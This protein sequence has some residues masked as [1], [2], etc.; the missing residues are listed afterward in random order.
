MIQANQYHQQLKNISQV[1]LNSGM[2]KLPAMTKTNGQPVKLD[3]QPDLMVH[4]LRRC[5]Y[6]FSTAELTF[7]QSIGLDAYLEYQLAPEEMNT[8]ALE[9]L[10]NQVFSSLQMSYAEIIARSRTD[11]DFNPAFELIAAT[12]IR[13]AYNPS[14]LFE[15]MVEFWSNHFNVNIFDGPIQVFKGVDDRDNVRPNALGNFRDLLHANAKSPAMLYYLDGF[16]NTADGPNENYARELMEL[17]TLGV[18]GGYSE[19]DVKEVARC[20]TGWTLSEQADE[21]FVFYAPNHDTGS[22]TV[23]GQFIPAGGGI[24]DGEAVLDILASHP[25]TAAFIAKKLCQR[26]ISDTPPQ[27]VIDAVAATFVQTDGDIKAILRTLFTHAEF[28]TSAGQKFK[29]PIE[30]VLSI[31]RSLSPLSTGRSFEFI[32]RQVRN[33]GQTPFSYPAPTGYSDES[34]SWLNTNALLDRWNLGFAIG[35]GDLGLGRNVDDDNTAGSGPLAAD[36]LS[37]PVLTMLGSARTAAA[38]TDRMVEQVLHHS[39]NQNDRDALIKLAADGEPVTVPLSLDQAMA[40]ARAV[41]AVLL[42]SRYFQQR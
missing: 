15:I 33:L 24:E 26:F 25:S 42:A 17:H 14:Q 39:I 27:A 34:S 38:I 22:K 20:F 7:A 11:N 9:N 35:F 21:L 37:I 4:F 32:Y 28:A 30:Y 8:D 6:G 5:S 2:G 10:L 36:F 13:A 3:E 18:N 29:R 19:D 16:S 23:L 1:L 41:L 40:S 31:F 12:L